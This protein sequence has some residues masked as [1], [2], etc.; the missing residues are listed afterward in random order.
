MRQPDSRRENAQPVM[1]SVPP[2]SGGA[3][4]IHVEWT[5]IAVSPD[6]SQL[7]FT[8]RPRGSPQSSLWVRPLSA[9]DARQIPGTNDATSIFW[10]PDGKSIGFFAS[11]KMKRIDLTGGAPVTICDVREGIGQTGT[12]GIDGQILFASV[13]GEA[14]MRVPASGGAQVEVIKPDPAR[15]ERRVSWPS[16]LPDG[17]RFV[18]LVGLDDDSGAI[19]LGAQDGTAR[20]ILRVKSAAQYVDPGYL[21]FAHDSTLIA[22]RF[23]AATGTLSGDPIA[24]A[25]RVNH[26]LSTGAAQFSASRNGVIAYLPHRDESHIAA[27]DRSGRELA[28]VRPRAGY[29]GL[30]VVARGRELLFARADPRTTTLDV[31]RL[32]LDRGVETRLTNDPGSEM[33]ALLDGDSNMIYSA[34]RGG[35]PRLYRRN[36]ATG[37]DEQLVTDQPGMQMVS[38]LSPD[39][40]WLLYSQRSARGNFDLLALSL[41]DRRVVPVRRSPADEDGGHFSRDGE[42]VAFIS[43]ESGRRE[44]YLAGFQPPGAPRAVSTG[45]GVAPRWSADGRELFYLSAGRIMSVPVR[46]AR[47]LEIGKASVLFALPSSLPWTD[48]DVTPDGRFIAIVPLQYAAAQPLTVIVDWPSLANRKN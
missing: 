2:P 40:R 41:S 46:V 9:V 28:E 38:D 43:D 13:Q 25:D 36:L 32:E 45:G 18:Y 16:L 30:R 15:K 44:V 24:I 8:A 27:F 26:F 48:F 31:W 35:A 12:W 20:E 5:A 10:A 29:Q 34:A 3:F 11:G 37:V 14:I 17:R 7:A 22:R 4:A 6:G 21:V 23:D 47:P 1:F 39:G 33:F 19:M 42:Y